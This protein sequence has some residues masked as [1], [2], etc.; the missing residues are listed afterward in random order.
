[1]EAAGA[2]AAA[3]ARRRSLAR[4]NTLE[5]AGSVDA[6]DFMSDEELGD[7]RAACHDEEIFIAIGEAI[8]T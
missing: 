3:G 6:L 8:G 4:H 5:S 1:M 7:S 2:G